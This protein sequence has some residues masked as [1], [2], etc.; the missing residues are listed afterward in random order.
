MIFLRHPITAAGPDVCYGQ[1]DIE[2]GEDAEQQ[3][4]GALSAIGPVHA[5][6]SSDLTRCRTV[7]ER[8]AARDQ[9]NPTYDA[10]LREYHFGEWEGQ[11]W[12]EIPRVE[13][14]PWTEDLW[15]IAPPGGETFAALHARVGQ[16][17]NDIPEG[18]LVVAHAGVIRAARMILTGVSFETVFAEKVPFC[19]PIT[20]TSRAA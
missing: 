13:S 1:L 16:V 15:G 2:L 14:D 6:H 4:A 10:R 7:A 17:L 5:I 11:S 18:A 12:S 19:Q 3:I 9:V 8:F 20:F